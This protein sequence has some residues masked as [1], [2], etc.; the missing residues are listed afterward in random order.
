MFENTS[1]KVSMP[2]PKN[3]QRM[4][5][6]LLNPLEHGDPNIQRPRC[7]KNVDVLRGCVRVGSVSE[8]REAFN[9]LSSTHKVVRVK[10]THDPS[11]AAWNGGYRSVLV[12]FIF[13]SGV[14]WQQLFGGKVTFDQRDWARMLQLKATPIEENQNLAGQLWTDLAFVEDWQLE[15]LYTTFGLQGLQIISSEHPNE[16]VKMIA[17]LQLVLEPYFEGRAVSHL[18]F[19]V[20]RCDTGSMEMVRDFFQ[21]YFHKEHREDINLL[22][23]QD[24]ALAVKEGREL[25]S[26]VEKVPQALPANLNRDDFR[27]D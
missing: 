5:N 7:A 18:L 19:K 11:S 24:I 1:V 10:N 21:E 9:R 26:R 16:T 20:A 23:V 14:T 17:E 25:P 3:L 12:N 13:D 27:F 2:A 8:L 6:K 15:E 4:Q 22:A